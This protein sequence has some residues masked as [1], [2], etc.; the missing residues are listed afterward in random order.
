MCVCVCVCVKLGKTRELAI[1]HRLKRIEN[2]RLV[3]DLKD[4]LKR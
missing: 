1:L 3:N 4:G 2:E